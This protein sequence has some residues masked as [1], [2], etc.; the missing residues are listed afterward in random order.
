[1]RWQADGE[2][3]ALT[4]HAADVDTS[5]VRLDGAHHGC[6]TK[7][8]AADAAG[9]VPAAAAP[10]EDEWNVGRRNSDSLIRDAAPRLRIVLRHRN[11]HATAIGAGLDGGGDEV[12]EARRELWGID[13][14][15]ERLRRLHD[16]LAAAA[17]RR[18]V[19]R[20]AANALDQV[21]RLRL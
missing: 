2:G 3:R 14:P 9:H 5:A 20:D 4:L 7:A 15:H 16:D 11:R 8:D 21:S 6:Q 13:A 19:A 17:Q 10:F 12:V 1:M 18:M